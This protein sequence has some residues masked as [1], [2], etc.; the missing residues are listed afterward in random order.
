[1]HKIKTAE[2]PKHWRRSVNGLSAAVAALA[3]VALG[4]ATSQTG[5]RPSIPAE[6]VEW[7]ERPTVGIDR[8]YEVK[9]AYRDANGAVVTTTVEMDQ[10]TLS[11]VRDGSPCIVPY[12]R[13]YTVSTCP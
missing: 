13:R 12:G 10:M 8:I 7:Q 9:V 1:V 4:C 3:M 11:R 5:R 2:S 6:I